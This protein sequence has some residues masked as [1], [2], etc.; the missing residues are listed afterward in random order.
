MAQHGYGR[1][2]SNAVLPSG[3][4]ATAHRPCTGAALPYLVVLVDGWEGLVSGWEA[5]DHGRTLDSMLRVLREGQA[6][7]IRAVVAGDRSVLASRVG[8]MS[9]KLVLRLTDATDLLMAGI[10]SAAV[11]VHQPPGRALR[12]SD[13]GRDAARP[14][15][16]WRGK[17]RQAAVLDAVARAG[18]A[19]R[20]A[21][22]GHV[23]ASTRAPFR[24]DALPTRVTLSTVQRDRAGTP[25]ARSRTGGG[26]RQRQPGGVV[27]LGGDHNDAVGSAR[28]GRGANALVAGPTA[29]RPL[30][31]VA[32]PGGP[33]A[34][35]RPTSGGA[36]R[37]PVA[38]V[39]PACRPRRRLGT[40][41]GG[42]RTRGVGVECR[43]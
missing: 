22:G 34:G 12:V 6:I 41:R 38:A 5:R 14:P 25:L 15:R 24:V 16:W 20:G 11:P 37:A 3:W 32:H 26:T 17:R 42:S 13:C 39:R 33:A 29:L 8:A 31:H 4:A 23:A 36:H 27:G 30:D 19:A 35:G 43:R 40:S 18:T 7:G 1:W 28:L 9:E 10:D 2:P 21:F